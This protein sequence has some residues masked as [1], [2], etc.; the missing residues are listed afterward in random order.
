MTYTQT[1]TKLFYLVEINGLQIVSSQLVNAYK[2][3]GLN[4]KK[5][6]IQLAGNYHN[7]ILLLQAI[8]QLK[9]AIVSW[10]DISI[11]QGNNDKLNIFVTFSMYNI[12]KK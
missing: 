9:G 8:M 3:I 5:L 2:V 6:E 4:K 11:K 12:I 7:F 1:L 10:Q